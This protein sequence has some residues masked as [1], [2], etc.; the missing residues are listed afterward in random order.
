MKQALCQL[1]DVIEHTWPA[2]S[3]RT[4]GGWILREG[5]GGGKR[6]SATT[7]HGFREAANINSAENDMRAFGQT[8]IFMIREGEE[9]LD[10]ILATEGYEITEPS[11]IYT[12]PIEKLVHKKPPPLSIFEIWE[13]LQIQADIWGYAGIDAARI[14]VMHRAAGPKTSF[15]MRWENRPAGTAFIGLHNN[16]VMLHALEVLP[17]QQRK[18]V[19]TLAM[20]QA[21]IWAKSF[22]AHTLSVICTRENLGA[23]ALYSSLHM[24]LVGGYHYRIKKE[25]E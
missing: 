12:V 1:H 8:P 6:V 19:G 3:T 17:H 16:V 20:H 4:H 21:A 24:Q 7:L 15:F 13:P 25:I 9:A 11:N 22:G 18:G 10:R 23:N 5:L 2:N 14:A